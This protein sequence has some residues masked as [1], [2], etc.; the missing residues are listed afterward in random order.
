LNCSLEVA[1]IP[2]EDQLLLLFQYVWFSIRAKGNHCGP[3]RQKVVRVASFALGLGGVLLL[4]P[5][6][7]WDISFQV[8]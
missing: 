2:G 7:A 6:G 3:G 8:L 4:T 1:V 5:C